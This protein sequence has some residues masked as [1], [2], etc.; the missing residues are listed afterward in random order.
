MSTRLPLPSLPSAEPVTAPR[1]GRTALEFAAVTLIWGSTWLIIKGQLGTV[2]PAW[3]VAYRFAIAGAVLAAATIATGRWRRLTVAQ[4]GFAV[5]VGL[6]Q[7]MLNFNLVYAAE[8]RLTSGLVSLVFALLVVPNTLLAALVFKTRVSAR[9]LIGTGLGIAGLALLFGR[10]LGG[11]GGAASGLGLV[12]LAVL[13]ASVANVLQASGF[14]R[15]SPS[16]P[17][18]ATAMGYG[19]LLDGGYAWATAG[20]PVFD[21][22]SEYWAGLAYL[23]LAASVVAFS[24]YYRLIRRIGPGPAAYSSVLV[25]V[26]ALALSTLFEGYRWTPAAGGGAALAL[27]GLA[28]ALGGVRGTPAARRESPGSAG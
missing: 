10:D 18:L 4:H 3:S 2:P 19:A 1:D 26:V 15:A 12:A 9:F 25:P 5:V 8:G 21:P 13:S 17:L 14:A 7:F 24:V 20:A 28:V 6:T 27:T 16:L 11:A 23:S 22:R